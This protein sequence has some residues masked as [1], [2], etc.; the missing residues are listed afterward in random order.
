M[1]KKQIVISEVKKLLEDGM[2]RKDITAL[3]QLNKRESDMLWQHPSLKG[4]KKAK[5]SVGIELIDDTPVETAQ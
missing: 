2:N 3:Y 4:I 5:Y 1:E